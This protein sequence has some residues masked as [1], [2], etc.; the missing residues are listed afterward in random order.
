M[1]NYNKQQNLYCKYCN[2]EC[3]SL[4]SLKQHEIRCK[5]NPN[6]ILSSFIE[7][8]KT[9][10]Y[11]HRIIKK[12]N[13]FIKAKELGLEKPQI[14][15]ETKYKLGKSWRDKYRSDKDKQKIKQT[16]QEKIKNNEWHLSFSKSR[17]VEYKGIKFLGRW[18]YLFAIYLDNHNI[19]WERPKK[20]FNYIFKNEN[21]KYLPDFYLPEYN[22]YIEIKGYPINKDF[23]KWEQCSENLDIYFGDDLYNLGIIDSYKDRYKNIDSKFRIKH[24]TLGL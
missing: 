14:S 23:A 22:L 24:I 10:D 9:I 18:E 8:N 13:Q 21:H 16:I 15:E 19:K 7:Y 11:K 1:D 6:H 20:M 3:T 17:I 4:N 12:S 2:K 5:E